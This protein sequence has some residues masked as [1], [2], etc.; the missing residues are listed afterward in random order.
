M[1]L[2][3]FNNQS[4]AVGLA[5]LEPNSVSGNFRESKVQRTVSALKPTPVGYASIAT[6]DGLQL[7]ATHHQNEIGCFSAAAWLAAA[8]SSAILIEM[9]DDDLYWLC[10]VEQG[11]VF[12]SGDIVGNYHQIEARL[13]ELV[14]DT[15][16]S[17]IVYFDNTQQFSSITDAAKAGFADLVNEIEPDSRGLCKPV[18]S[19]NLKVPLFTLAA[20]LFLM[21]GGFGVWKVYES[22]IASKESVNTVNIELERANARQREKAE[23]ELKLTQDPGALLSLFIDEVY[24]RPIRAGGWQA[25]THEW[26]PDGAKT[27]WQRSHGKISD[28]VSELRTSD[29]NF[30]ES[31]GMVTEQFELIMPSTELLPTEDRLGGVNERIE[32]IDLLAE[33]PGRWTLGP[34]TTTGKLFQAR[35]SSIQGSNTTMTTAIHVAH[36][37]RNYPVLLTKIKTDLIE[38]IQ[39]QIEGDYYENFD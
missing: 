36:W 15:A 32:F 13:E 14:M 22:H 24:N 4:V 18:K 1:A 19:K 39:W 9:L 17:D 16:G 37:L 35:K 26:S 30:D 20:S 34:S 28:L 12:P 23:L 33:T 6:R 7:G 38:P 29:W 31:T 2:F 3:S 8:K 25:V 5:W 21:V 10:A 11:S 27:L